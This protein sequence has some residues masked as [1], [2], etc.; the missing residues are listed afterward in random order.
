MDW[1]GSVWMVVSAEG[2]MEEFGRG[3]QE[4]FWVNKTLCFLGIDI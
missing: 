4:V 3:I 1:G 2:L